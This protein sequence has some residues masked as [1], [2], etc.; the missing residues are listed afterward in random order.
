ME[1]SSIIDII[2]VGVLLLGAYEGYKQGFLL[3]ILG[4]FGFVI[5]VILGFY[6]MDPLAAWLGEN[7]ESVNIS[8]PVIGFLI[9]FVISLLLIRIFG[10]VL[11]KV[12]DLTILGT[13]DSF[14]GVLF[15]VVKAGFFLSLFLW[16]TKE[17]DFDF[18]KK[19]ERNSEMIGYIEP[20]AP[21]VIDSVSPFFPEVESTKSSFEKLVEKVKDVTVDR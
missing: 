9:I 6:F 2:I 5:A 19:W 15:G 10:W 3:G 12:M 11:K 14:A 1:S 8:Y 16:F 20:W 18:P 17:F 13:F 7:V 4:L 21:G